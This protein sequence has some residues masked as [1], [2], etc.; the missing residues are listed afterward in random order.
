[1]MLSD[2]LRYPV[3]S[4]GWVRTI[5]IGGLLSLLSVLVLPAFFQQGYYVR[6]LRG[7]TNGDPTPPKFDEWLELLIDGL[8]LFVVNIVVALVVF[9]VLAVVGIMFG[10]GSLLLD[11]ATADPG[12]ASPGLFGALGA[13]GTLVFVGATILIGYV[14]PGMFANFARKDSIGAAF[15]LSTV[16]SGT[17]TEE[18]LVGWVLAVVVGLVLGFVASLLSL[19]IVGIF[20]LFYVQVATYYLFGRGFV[21]GLEADGGDAT[22]VTY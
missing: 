12:A 18:Y 22:A 15:D 4:D 11:A 9:A 16:I 6:V 19:L 1:M 7:V 2:A 14:A 8:K 10:T 3:D 20:G 13:L 21:E 5:L 17:M